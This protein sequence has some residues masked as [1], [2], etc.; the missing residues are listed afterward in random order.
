MKLFTQAQIAK[1]IESLPKKARWTPRQREI[2]GFQ[3]NYGKFS[4]ILKKSDFMTDK[5]FDDFL[6]NENNQATA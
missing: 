5:E 6:A 1:Y 2:L 3:S 4:G